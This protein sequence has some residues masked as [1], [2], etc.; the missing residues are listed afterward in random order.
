MLWTL[1]ITDE[2][3]NIPKRILLDVEK[4]VNFHSG[5]RYWDDWEPSKEFSA[6]N[7]HLAFQERKLVF[8]MDSKRIYLFDFDSVVNADLEPRPMNL[9]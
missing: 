3:D 9:E 1:N 8:T 5:T 4:E 2:S 6:E 7:Y